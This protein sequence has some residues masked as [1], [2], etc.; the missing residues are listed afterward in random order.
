MPGIF[1]LFNGGNQ[2][3]CVLTRPGES[4]PTN[5]PVPCPLCFGGASAADLDCE[6]SPLQDCREAET[7]LFRSLD[8]T[9]DICLQV[10]AQA[11]WRCGCPALPPPRAVPFCSLC[12]NGSFPSN[13]DAV[14]DFA[15][16]EEWDGSYRES[17]CASLATSLSYASSL[18]NFVPFNSCKGYQDEYGDVCGCSDSSTISPPP[19]SPASASCVPSMS[20]WLLISAS[21]TVLLTLAS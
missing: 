11:Y 21:I 2:E 17:T 20:S 8:E 15:L 13:P 18:D 12:S 14:I 10:N 5:S 3:S 4:A 9:E 1:Q 16:P 6:Y 7:Y 19:T